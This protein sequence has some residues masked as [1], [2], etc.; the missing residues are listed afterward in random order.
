MNAVE[1]IVEC[2]FRYCK[3]CFTMTDVKIRGGNNRQCDLLAYNVAS[4]EQYH[5]ESSVTHSTSWLSSI[6]EELR[7]KFDIKFRGTSPQRE[8]KNTDYAKGK[9]YFDNI[10]Q[11][12][13]AIGFD[14]SKV[15]RVF[16]T[17]TIPDEE[18]L[19]KM[20]ADYRA[21]HGMSIEVWSLR[22]SIIPELLNKVSTGNYDDEVLR[23]LSLLRQRDV[24]LKK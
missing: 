5:V 13:Q 10:V 4:Q 15:Q 18:A 9:T 7:G 17:W 16:V 20:L 24:Q 6:V 22:D 1:H 23:T 14:P 11:T 3:G 8:G 2:Y 21:Q 19:V 12:Y